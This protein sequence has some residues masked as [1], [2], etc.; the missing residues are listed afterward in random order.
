MQCV[1][2][3]AAAGCGVVWAAPVFWDAGWM[4][5]AG[6][7]TAVQSLSKAADWLESPICPF[8]K[9]AACKMGIL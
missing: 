5:G 7:D 9:G 3:E 1:G 4:H 8:L 2:R 6:A